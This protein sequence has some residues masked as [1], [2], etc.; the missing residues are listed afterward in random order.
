MNFKEDGGQELIYKDTFEGKLETMTVSVHPEAY[1][2]TLFAL[3]IK[4][5]DDNTYSINA[6]E[7]D[8]IQL[9]YNHTLPYVGLKD[10]FCNIKHIAKIKESDKKINNI[11]E[12]KAGD[13]LVISIEGAILSEDKEDD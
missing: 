13:E 12:M 9:L 8:G 7:T 11:N 6:I 10:N 3:T 2:V 1:M 4:K 5:N